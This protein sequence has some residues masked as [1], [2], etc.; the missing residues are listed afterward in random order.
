MSKP[1]PA[2]GASRVLAYLRSAYGIADATAHYGS[3][4]PYVELWHNGKRCR[5]TI[6][7]NA[8][9]WGL[10]RQDIARLL[11]PPP[12]QRKEAVKRTLSQLT[13]Q[14]ESEA[15]SILPA[16]TPASAFVHPS[17]PTPSPASTPTTI[18]A[19][20]IRIGVY[21]SD[22]RHPDHRV[23]HVSF[24]NNSIKR[25]FPGLKT[26]SRFNYDT[27]CAEIKLWI[28]ETG[29]GTT[30]TKTTKTA[31]RVVLH[32]RDKLTPSKAIA[33][34]SA[35]MVDGKLCLVLAAA[36]PLDTKRQP[37]SKRTPTPKPAPFVTAA[38]IEEATDM[39]PTSPQAP[40]GPRTLL[41]DDLRAAL[42]LIAELEQRSAYR[43][44]RVRALDGSEN[45]EWRAPTI[46]L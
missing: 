30:Y 39:R 18:A 19:D 22:K 2:E 33:P 21:A 8:K 38:M 36:Q 23:I 9:Q 40:Q 6:N 41:A 13:A 12:A 28:S 29:S 34:S 44:T 20:A 11:G 7:P 46:R 32:A 26:D 14:L 16:L 25:I 1:A 27:D 24:L 42:T 4:H 45:W 10:K 43:L 35:T 15:M 37:L 31:T 3:R 17:S 5:I